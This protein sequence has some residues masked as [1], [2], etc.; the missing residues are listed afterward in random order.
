MYFF[1]QEKGFGSGNLDRL[2]STHFKHAD[3]VVNA[4]SGIIIVDIEIE[5]DRIKSDHCHV[6][7]NTARMNEKFLNLM[8]TIVTIV[9]VDCNDH[10]NI[11]EY[12]SENPNVK[13]YHAS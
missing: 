4:D 1:T 7:S 5:P 10:I 11:D 3:H 6:T 8:L 2:K 13:P 12:F 9:I